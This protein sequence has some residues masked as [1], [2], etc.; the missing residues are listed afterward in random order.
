[1]AMNEKDDVGTLYKC[2]ECGKMYKTHRGLSR[3][4]A[5]KHGDASIISSSYS[6][7]FS[8]VVVKE[9]SEKSAEKVSKEDYYPE[10]I[11]MELK[12]F[13][14]D[15]NQAEKIYV[16]FKDVIETYSTHPE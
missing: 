16:L 3:H 15:L 14:L 7:K 12:C 9:L 1:M 4:Q 8:P 13:S 10:N 5:A 6:S 2:D 11:I